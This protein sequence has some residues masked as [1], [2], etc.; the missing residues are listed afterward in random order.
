MKKYLTPSKNNRSPP[1]MIL[2]VMQYIAQHCEWPE[3]YA[4]S[5]TCR[6]I[7]ERV[8]PILHSH[9]PRLKA[10]IESFIQIDCIWSNGD[11]QWSVGTSQKTKI[12]MPKRVRYY[13][14]A[15]D[16]H[17]FFGL[18]ILFCRCV[19]KAPAL[20]DVPYPVEF[21]RFSRIAG[22]LKMPYRPREWLTK[23]WVLFGLFTQWLNVAF[24]P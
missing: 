18:L 23:K 20:R 6:S 5:L 14:F 22:I 24:Q 8:L 1:P 19:N 10:R 13:P 9:V 2:D 11:I 15:S 12:G 7:R 16:C 3:V 4:L 21:V 17:N